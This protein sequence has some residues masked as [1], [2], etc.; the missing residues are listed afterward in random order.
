MPD[1]RRWRTVRGM[2]VLRLVRDHADLAFALACTVAL[3]IEVWLSSYSTHRPALA[4]LCLLVTLPLA[5]RCRYPL[6]AFLCIILSFLTITR[7]T[8][9][10][11][12]S[13]VIVIA[14]VFALYSYGANARGRQAWAAVILMPLLIG[15]FVTDDGD[16]F[17]W[18]DVVFGAL[19]IGGPWLAGLMI[20]LRR[21]S[22]RSLT[23][24][25]VELER[26]KEERARAPSPRSGP[27][28]RASCTTWSPTRQRDR[29]AGARRP[30]T[31]STSRPR[32]GARAALD[33]IEH[34]GARGAR[35]DAPAARRA[36]G[37]RRGARSAPQPGARAAR[38][39]GRAGARRGPRRSSSRSRASRPSS[40]P[41]RRPVRLPD[42]A[43]GADERAQARRP[44]ERAR[45]TSS[46]TADGVEV[47]V[48]DDGGARATAAERRA[49]ASSA[50]ASGSPLL[51]GELEAGP[52]PDGGFA[53][54][55]A[56]PYR[57]RRRRDPRPSIADDQALVRTRL[58][59]DPRGASPTSR[60]SAR[61]A[62]A[63]RRSRSSRELRPDVV[64]MDVRMPEM[65][66][67]EATR[68]IVADETSAARCS[69]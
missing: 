30:T 62:T 19:I 60:S 57:L 40:P 20:R 68:R 35:R 34:T 46:A 27:G 22:E 50:C 43:G 2:R 4:L 69:C 8:N 9:F 38:R 21:Q 11:N 31:C 18:G 5:L 13:A 14:L 41:G 56:L 42:R 28:S 24:R 51:G 29:R 58:P 6:A 48:A 17:H 23:M 59:D 7:I 52:A 39:A 53:C 32:R 64:L 44:G 1:A 49:R 63:A 55:R 16:P 54:A 3:Q 37:Q 65:D 25:T 33:A 26:D 66:G 61:P 12:S 36:A 45:S 47:D 15:N 10:D 67:I